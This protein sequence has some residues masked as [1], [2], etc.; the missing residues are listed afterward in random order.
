MTTRFAHPRLGVIGVAL[1]AALLIVVTLLASRSGRSDAPVDV[2]ATTVAGPP[3][4]E[5]VPLEVG[6]VLA[7]APSGGAAPLVDGVG[8]DAGEQV[9]YH[10]HTHVAVYVDGVL[11][12]LP[13]GIGLVTPVEQS[14]PGGPFDVAT[15]CYYWLHVHARDGVVHIESPTKAA[16]T[17]GQFFDLWRQPL[18]M[19]R[20]GP[21][22]GPVTLYVNGRRET[23]DPRTVVLGSHE[24]IQLEVGT[25]AVAPQ[26]VDWSRTRL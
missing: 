24:D 4:P 14:A 2:S 5:G 19:G 15:D 18:S 20:V 26:K 13:A 23:A 9:A 8:C 16:Y 12:P 1:A 21:A 22:L 6:P 17:L 10:V 25:P 11:R 7:P 3:G